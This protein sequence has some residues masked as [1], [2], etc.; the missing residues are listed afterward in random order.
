[1]RGTGLVIGRR[2]VLVLLLTGVAWGRGVLGWSEVA[3]QG[4]TWD[5]PTLLST[6]SGWSWFP[7]VVVDYAGRVHVFY[8]SSLPATERREGVTTVM[9]TV[10][11][12]G[13][14]SEPNDVLTGRDIFRVAAAIDPLGNIHIVRRHMGMWHHMAPLD[15]A[16]SAAS[17]NR[18][19]LDQGVLYMCDV[20]VD[21]ENVIHVVYERWVMLDEPIV[22]ERVGGDRTIY[23]LSDIYYRRS[24][25]GG[26][27]WSPSVNLSKSPRVGSY[28]VQMTLDANDVIH[29]TWDEGWD[30]WS[31]YDEPREGVYIRSTDGGNTWSRPTVFFAP[32]RTNAQ[33]AM[34]TDNQG[35]ILVVW[36]ATTR[37]QLYYARSSDGGGS[38]SALRDISGIYARPY[39]DTPFDAYQMATDS[40]GKIHLVVVGS[41]RLPRVPNERVPLGVYHLVW[42]GT[43]WSDPEQIA[44]YTPEVGFPEYPRL[45]IGKGNQLH[46]V[47]FVRDRLFGT[48]EMDVFYSRLESDA[49]RVTVALPL[50]LTPTPRVIPSPT[51]VPSAMAPTL[52]LTAAGLPSGLYTEMDDVL[53]LALAVAPIAIVVL[54]LIAV[55]LGWIRR[56]L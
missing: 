55:R 41:V 4:G 56:R 6:N 27:I 23:G 35:H 3:A 34:G 46:V 8:D 52:A 19:L 20:V 48:D 26:R 43:R 18:H 12:G 25:D 14:W 9:Y 11:Q 2:F 51:P 29:V 42:D 40:A 44:V 38:W 31:E 1:M 39:N 10:E 16:G 21:R 33:T 45:A 47:W 50:T 37:A 49:P 15:D 53:R 7:D 28:R 13:V 36:R 54:L 32:E 30:R 24:A 22:V 5:R 17:W